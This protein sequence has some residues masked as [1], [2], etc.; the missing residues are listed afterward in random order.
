MILVSYCKLGL[1]CTY[2]SSSNEHLSDSV[3]LKK[4]FKRGLVI[5]VCPE[6]F[7]GLSTPRDPSEIRGGNGFD[8]IEGRAKLYSNKGIEVT[9]NFIDG[10][11]MSAGIAEKYGVKAAVLTECSPSCGV[12]Y[13][14]DGTFTKNKIE[15]PGVLGA[16]LIKR[17]GPSFPV[18]GQADKNV[19]NFL[20]N[21]FDKR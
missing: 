9:K 12:K 21:F 16:L 5:G 7:G 8:V 11:I 3:F 6:I 15:G 2:K 14:Y 18:F 4:M 19:E 17:F 10:A 13:V 20:L 1:N